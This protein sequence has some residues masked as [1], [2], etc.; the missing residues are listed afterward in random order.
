MLKH[1]LLRKILK[2][3]DKKVFAG[4]PNRPPGPVLTQYDPLI[5]PPLKGSRKGNLVDHPQ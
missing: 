4:Q 5:M 1:H 3:M 2:K